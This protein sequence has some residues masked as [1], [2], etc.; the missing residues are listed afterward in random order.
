ML[1]LAILA[2]LCFQYLFAYDDRYYV[3]NFADSIRVV[4]VCTYIEHLSEPHSLPLFTYGYRGDYIT[5]EYGWLELKTC[6][7]HTE[8]LFRKPVYHHTAPKAHSYWIDR[9]TELYYSTKYH[10]DGY[11]TPD[12]HTTTA[13]VETQMVRPF[14]TAD[15]LKRIGCG[16]LGITPSECTSKGCCWNPTTHYENETYVKVP[17]CFIKGTPDTLELPIAHTNKCPFEYFNQ[18]QIVQGARTFYGVKLNFTN[19]EKY[20][21]SKSCARSDKDNEWSDISLEPRQVFDDFPPIEAGGY[22]MNPTYYH[23]HNYVIPTYRDL[24]IPCS[25]AHKKVGTK[26]GLY[27]LV[28]HSLSTTD[29]NG[30]VIETQA[31]CAKACTSDGCRTWDIDGNLYYLNSCLMS[32][33]SVTLMSYEHSTTIQMLPEGYLLTFNLYYARASVPDC[34]PPYPSF[35]VAGVCVYLDEPMRFGNYGNISVMTFNHDPPGPGSASWSPGAI[36]ALGRRTTRDT[37]YGLK[38]FSVP[39]SSHAILSVNPSSGILTG[40]AYLSAYLTAASTRIHVSCTN[41]TCAVDAPLLSSFSIPIAP[42]GD[43]TYKPLK[44]ISYSGNVFAPTV[45]AS[46][47]LTWSSYALQRYVLPSYVTG[48]IVTAGILI[49]GC[50]IRMWAA[51]A[52]SDHLKVIPRRAKVWRAIFGGLA[53]FSILF[54]GLLD[55]FMCVVLLPLNICLLPF[56]RMVMFFPVTSY[57]TRKLFKKYKVVSKVLRP[58]VRTVWPANRDMPAWRTLF[59]LTPFLISIVSCS[60][61]GSQSSS[62]RFIASKASEGDTARFTIDESITIPATRG[63]ELEYTALD[64]SG[65]T[66]FTG[67]VRIGE[68]TAVPALCDYAYSGLPYKAET[69]VYK[70]NFNEHCECAHQHKGPRCWFWES[71]RRNGDC[72][73]SFESPVD[74]TL[75][76]T[77]RCDASDVDNIPIPSNWDVKACGGTAIYSNLLDIGLLGRGSE[78]VFCSATPIPTHDRVDVY[79]CANSPAIVTAIIWQRDSSGNLL[80]EEE[81]E[82]SSTEAIEND[83]MRVVVDA[84]TMQV[85]LPAFLGIMYMPSAPPEMLAELTPFNTPDSS[86]AKFVGIP[87][88]TISVAA[89]VDITTSGLSCVFGSPQNLDPGNIR[90]NYLPLTARTKCIHEIQ[91]PEDYIVNGYRRAGQVG[92]PFV[93]AQSDCNDKDCIP[94]SVNMPRLTLSSFNC[95]NYVTVH[96]RTSADVQVSSEVEYIDAASISCSTCT[97]YWGS[98][99]ASCSCTFAVSGVYSSLPSSVTSTPLVLAVSEPGTLDVRFTFANPYDNAWTS[100]QGGYVTLPVDGLSEPPFV[101]PCVTCGGDGTDDTGINPPLVDNWWDTYKWIVITVLCIAAPFIFIVLFCCLLPKFLQ[102]GITQVNKINPQLIKA[103]SRSNKMA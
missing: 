99:G 71:C 67:G 86:F 39:I 88:A 23:D 95:D 96:L 74:P 13:P 27:N 43:P 53:Y 64:S 24:G 83:N 66:V 36:D 73:T 97:G 30:D 81:I 55:I 5:S 29:V 46:P 31:C 2:S 59:I 76:S 101:V 40:P 63:F 61:L 69:F 103:A 9:S 11:G 91:Q 38:N 33:V 22:F 15:P 1:V 52:F 14:C 12:L 102:A 65:S 56:S 17:W 47:F 49:A 78:V 48:I 45:W 94:F 25:T 34:P 80:Y 87:S 21:G 57:L 4:K 79:K 98:Q 8:D 58:R 70:D 7:N 51:L 90:A 19:S 20:V 85:D 82:V 77:S 50:Y 18:S 35:R 68:K 75:T 10:H 60:T 62:A 92:I 37:F 89:N 100:T 3:A 84:T 44:L 42:A 41:K 93:D 26:Y 28:A 72:P 54:P 32:P 6:S 16:H